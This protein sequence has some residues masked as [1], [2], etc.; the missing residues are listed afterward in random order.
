MKEMDDKIK[1][2][3]DKNDGAIIFTW[4]D[5]QEQFLVP[6]GDDERCDMIRSSIAFFV[7][8]TQRLDWIK[9]FNDEMADVFANERE[10]KKAEE[11]ER[12]RSHLR[13]IK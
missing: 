1:L 9:E 3:F 13:V 8:A 10:E 11:K 6:I 12:E 7:Y 5:S 2:E 4:D